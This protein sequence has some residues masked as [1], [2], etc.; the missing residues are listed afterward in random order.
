MASL[1]VRITI[2]TS[3]KSQSN[4][5]FVLMECTQISTKAN[6]RYTDETVA[7]DE[8]RI[9]SRHHKKILFSGLNSLAVYKCKIKFTLSINPN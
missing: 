6:A 1:I 8:K 7:I 2:P 4:H 3:Y 9:C 5:S